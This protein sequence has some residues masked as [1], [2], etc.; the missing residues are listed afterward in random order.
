V[1]S[2]VASRTEVGPVETAA[3][4]RIRLPF[5][6]ES[7]VLT[8]AASMQ[9]PHQQRLRRAPAADDPR[10]GAAPA[11]SADLL[12]LCDEVGYIPFDPRRQPDVVSRRYE[13]A[14][15]I[16][17]P[18]PPR[19]STASARARLTELPRYLARPRVSRRS[20]S[21]RLGRGEGLPKEKSPRFTLVNR[22][23]ATYVS[24]LTRARRPLDAT[25]LERVR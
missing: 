15:L 20:R 8:N 4:G 14:T 13:C 24:K 25:H 6:V 12:L 19:R 10:G 5:A 18:A 2:E 7:H 3:W 16:T 21:A 17:P 1:S 11:W 23:A 9:A 22:G